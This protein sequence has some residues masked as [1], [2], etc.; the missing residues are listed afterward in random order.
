MTAAYFRFYADLNEFLPAHK[1]YCSSPFPVSDGNQTVK[2]LI[3]AQ[4]IPHTEVS[5]ILADSNPVGF[6]H[7]VSSGERISVYPPFANL[8]LD[9]VF[10]LRGPLPDPPRFLLD[11]HLGRLA[12]YLRLLG[13]DA[14][15]LNNQLDDAQLADLAYQEQRI[16]LSRDRG[17]LKRRQVEF[18]YCL[19]SMDSYE[20]LLAVIHRYRLQ[21]NIAPWSRCLKCNGQLH[22][23]NKDDISERLEPKTRR[24]FDEFRQCLD[25]GQVYWQGSHY[26]RLRSFV[27]QILDHF[28]D[29]T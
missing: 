20:Q 11:N 26:G 10:R 5:L 15:Y 7:C 9:E 22:D 1:R 27:S 18:G 3:E 6:S 19:R 23:A 21:E 2:H 28:P 12:R 17:L 8:D 14:L 25:C 24:Y 16:L 13:L 29:S 4:G